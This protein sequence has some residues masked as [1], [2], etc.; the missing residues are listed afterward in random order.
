MSLGLSTRAGSVAVLTSVLSIA[1][2]G[3]SLAQERGTRQ[4][5]GKPAP[6][7]GYQKSASAQERASGVI[8]K[9]ERVTKGATE[10]STIDKRAEAGREHDATVRL[11]IN[12]AAVW[13]DW[14]RDQA[15]TKD[16]GPPQKDARKG[17]NSVATKGEPNE[18]NSL[19]VVDI[20]P[21]TRV[22]TRFRDENDESTKGSTTPAKARSEAGSGTR[23]SESAKSVQFRKEDLRPGLFV[24]V[25]FRHVP[26]QNPAQSVAVIRPI[27]ASQDRPK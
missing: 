17:A 8:V 1:A 10:G 18:P 16:S 22:E 19:V 5:K 6:G 2:S 26:A 24:E 11:T 21:A 14:A 7:A 25:D 9:V 23:N 3:L 20:V 12:T 13:R 4:E 27:I 15:Q